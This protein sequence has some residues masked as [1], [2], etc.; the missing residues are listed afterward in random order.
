MNKH[1]IGF[2]ISAVFVYI[3]LTIS[4]AAERHVAVAVGSHYSKSFAAEIQQIDQTR[5]EQLHQ[6]PTESARTGQLV[7]YARRATRAVIALL[8]A[9]FITII[10]RLKKRR[11]PNNAL[12]PTATAP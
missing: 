3:L 12:E 5:S 1:I 7:L 2:I 6:N 8:F 9:A 4:S 10:A 11:E